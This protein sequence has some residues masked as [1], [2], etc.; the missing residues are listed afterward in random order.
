MLSSP[1]FK[2]ESKS[3]VER[4]GGAANAGTTQPHTISITRTKLREILTRWLFTSQDFA[5]S[6]APPARRVGMKLQS[7]EPPAH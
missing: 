3:A 7:K 1:L 2:S 6:V 4:C 5:G